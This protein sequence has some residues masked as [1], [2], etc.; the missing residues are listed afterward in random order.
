MEIRR[1][2]ELRARIDKALASYLGAK[3]K[4][5]D[6][7]R[8]VGYINPSADVYVDGNR[9]L[10]FIETPDLIEDSVKIDL[11]DG[12]VCFTASKRITR[13]T[14]RKYL[15]IERKIGTFTKRIPVAF[16]NRPVISMKNSYKLGVVKIDVEY[17]EKK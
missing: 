9:Q 16:Q 5:P 13:H 6:S 10:I 1:I 4:S 12:S 11:A 3:K 2:L 7:G 8:D 17:G 15:Q 14:E